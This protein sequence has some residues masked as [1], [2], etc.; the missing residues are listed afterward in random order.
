MKKIKSGNIKANFIEKF[1]YIVKQEL[2]GLIRPIRN[3]CRCPKCRSIGTYKP[4]GFLTGD[5]KASGRRWICKWC[6]YYYGLI[7][8]DFKT[9]D[10]FITLCRESDENDP[11]ITDANK[12]KGI[13]FHWYDDD[14]SLAKKGFFGF[15]ES[16]RRFNV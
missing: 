4:H 9:R 1:L 10:P 3:R 15:D 12:D 14:A 16:T 13:L 8:G 5:S 7:D 11:T 2:I 6:G